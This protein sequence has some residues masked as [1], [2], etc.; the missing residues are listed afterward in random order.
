MF[1]VSKVQRGGLLVQWSETSKQLQQLVD[2]FN[3][4]S[5]SNES[6]KTSCSK[7]A[8]KNQYVFFELGYRLLPYTNDL[9]AVSL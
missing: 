5:F 6:S 9:L 3:R 1:A 8:I 7:R 2:R 4:Q